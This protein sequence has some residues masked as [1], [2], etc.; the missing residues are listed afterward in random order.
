MTE[1]V[2]ENVFIS[3]SHRDEEWLDAFSRMLR[4]AVQAN[5]IDVW[6][7]KRI[8]SG[9]AW[10]TSIEAALKSARSALLLV[11]DS[12]LES[13]F[14]TQHELPKILSAAASGGLAI[15]W[16]PI[17]STLHELTPLA[18]IQ[19][20]WD[21]SRPLNSLDESARQE[22]IRSICWDMCAELGQAS[23]IGA[24]ERD[25]LKDS[26]RAAISD[27]YEL[28][29][30][31]G[32]GQNSIVYRASREGEPVVIKALVESGLSDGIAEE[33]ANNARIA[34]NLR[35][36]VFINIL[37]VVHH[38]KPRC[39]ITEY[40]SGVTLSQSIHSRGTIPV[41][42]AVAIL[43][44]LCEGLS[45]VHEIGINYGIV[46]P[47][48]VLLQDSRPRLSALGFWQYLSRG[49]SLPG[50]QLLNSFAVSYI[51]PEH[52]YGLETTPHTDQ[53]SLG[54][55]ALEMLEG[56]RP[57]TV[58]CPADFEKKR[59][60]FE[61][62]LAGAGTWADHHPV[63]AQTIAKMLAVNAKDRW[64][65]LSATADALG[66]LEAESITVAKNSYLE[67]CYEAPEFYAAFYAHLFALCPAIGDFF[68][69]CAMDAQYR[70]LDGAVQSLLNFHG[71]P[72]AEP[73]VLTGIADRHRALAIK[74]EHFDHFSDALIETL[75][76]VTAGDEAVVQAWATTVRPGLAYMRRKCEPRT[77][78]LESW[79]R[80]SI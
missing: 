61:D 57:V 43:R 69:N 22:A 32:S 65:S 51:A 41:D 47:Q 19:A 2:R 74:P 39:L 79:V 15:H 72:I 37:D 38:T 24:L 73:T 78:S 62:P 8:A 45:E 20:S 68:E 31:I 17:S 9:G 21:P 7:D 16:V 42:E 30:V 46:R 13:D 28:E 29:E 49:K 67:H 77:T 59:N 63:L 26:I 6:S 40:V 60:F 64:S 4:P 1:Q 54:L 56:S 10:R 14:I 33:F 18:D 34:T 27:R 36:P 80:S 55:V 70:M 50:N 44:T 48:N 76:E 75:R 23:R 52:Y 71:A 58:R 11:T 35:H 3:Y 12:F 53:Y 25:E 66:A 5:I